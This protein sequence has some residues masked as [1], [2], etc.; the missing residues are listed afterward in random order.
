MKGII[1]LTVI[2]CLQFATNAQQIQMNIQMNPDEIMT[3]Q[4]WQMDDPQTEF[5]RPVVESLLKETRK[6]YD[7][8][9]QSEPGNFTFD[10][11]VL[12]SLILEAD[13]LQI[14]LIAFHQ[15]FDL[16]NSYR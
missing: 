13:K 9:N 1:L 12:D 2:L 7:M 3:Q 14:N 16:I 11:S 5:A 15:D 6:F 4:S 8:L 10:F